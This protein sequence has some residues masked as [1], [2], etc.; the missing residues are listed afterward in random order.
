VPLR[1]ACDPASNLCCR[2]EETLCPAENTFGNART[3]C[4]PQGGHC[5]SAADCCLK[6]EDRDWNRDSCGSDGIC[7][8]NDAYCGFDEQCVGGRRCIGLCVGRGQG[9][10]LCSSSAEC[11][12]EQ[13]CDQM[14]CIHPD[15][16]PR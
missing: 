14:R 6:I 16:L 1:G 4:R 8:G 9:F 5:S 12:R 11:P 15:D 2:S 13:A 7:G 10:K 3:C